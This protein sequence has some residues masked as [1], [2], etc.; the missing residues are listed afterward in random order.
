M[1][2][3]LSFCSVLCTFLFSDFFI[4]LLWILSFLYFHKLEKPSYMPHGK[5]KIEVKNNNDSPFANK[6]RDKNTEKSS[7]TSIDH[8]E[9][10]IKLLEGW[11]FEQDNFKEESS[12]AEEHL[13][14]LQN[15][16]K[17]LK[18]IQIVVES[19]RI[20]NSYGLSHNICSDEFQRSWYVVERFEHITAY[21]DLKLCMMKV[22]KSHF[23]IWLEQLK[24][25][26]IWLSEAVEIQEK[27]HSVA[28]ES[29]SAV[30]HH[31]NMQ[32]VLL[33]ESTFMKEELE[34]CE[35][36]SCKLTI[37]LKEIGWWS[38]KFQQSMIRKQFKKQTHEKRWND[39][40]CD[41]ITE[42]M[43][44][45]AERYSLFTKLNQCY[46]THLKD[47]LKMTFPDP[48]T[49]LPERKPANSAVTICWKE[50][51]IQEL[52]SKES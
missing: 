36:D 33:N 10:Y 15:S 6:V 39:I 43:V 52:L 44:H 9:K 31:L 16:C 25:L 51:E 14:E 40:L 11:L 24:R 30:K 37:I 18:K 48:S 19:I 46:T 42:E 21:I 17:V 35:I 4:V 38:D 50:V 41:S 3:M 8:A 12:S 47:L 20:N 7:F 34:K 2:N 32:E 5:T 27:L 13:L 22:F 28:C 29:K 26:K 45:F 49:P 23:D 1:G